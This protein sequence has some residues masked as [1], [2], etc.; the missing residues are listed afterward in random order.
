MSLI[1]VQSSN[2]AAVGYS[3]FGAILTVTFHSGGIYQ[4]SG[5]PYAVYAGLMQAQSHGRF[6]WVYIRNRYPYRRIR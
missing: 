3:P 1:Q 6:F 2:L 5:V 4:Y